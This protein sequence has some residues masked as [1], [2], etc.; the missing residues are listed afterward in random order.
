MKAIEKGLLRK[1]TRRWGPRTIDLD[2]LLYGETGYKSQ[3]LEI[4]HPRMTDRGF[5]LLPLLQLN[6]ALMINRKAIGKWLDLVDCSEI[7]EIRTAD[8]WWIIR[9]WRSW[10]KPSCDQDACQSQ[11]RVC[12][13]PE[14]KSSSA[15]DFYCPC[16]QPEPRARSLRLMFTTS[17]LRL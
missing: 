13:R 11:E 2:I 16:W 14:P 7:V 5:V 10:L 15:C 8:E 4:P 3:A 9:V 17:L 12:H 6:D 1:K